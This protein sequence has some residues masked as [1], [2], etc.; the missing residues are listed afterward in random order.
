MDNLE[1]DVPVEFE[2]CFC[3][4]K[5][6]KEYTDAEGVISL[7]TSDFHKPICLEMRMAAASRQV[8]QFG[9]LPPDVA[10][11]HQ[12][13]LQQQQQQLPAYSLASLMPIISQSSSTSSSYGTTTST[14][15]AL[16]LEVTQRYG[17][18]I[19]SNFNH[20]YNNNFNTTTVGAAGL[21]GLGAVGA[22]NG[23]L[24]FGNGNYAGICSIGGG[25]GIGS[26]S[27][28]NNNNNADLASVD[29]SDTYA[30]CQTHPFLSQGDLTA[31]FNDEACALDIDMDNLYINP[32]EKESCRGPN[33]SSSTGFI[34]GLPPTI[35]ASGLTMRAQ[36]KKSASGDTALRNLAAGGL[37]PLDDVYQNFDVQ[38]RGSRVS[39]NENSVPKHRKTRFQQSFTSMRPS[40]SSSSKPRARFEDTKLCEDNVRLDGT[41]SG[42][43]SGAS[44]STSSA[45]AAG[46]GG[47]KKKRSAF[48]PGKSLATATKLINQRLFGIQ[49]AGAK[50]KFESKHSSSIDSIDA[51]PNLEHHRRSKSILKNKS[52]VSRVLS[53]PES[54]RLLADNM[55]GSGVSDNGT[56]MGESGSDYSPNKL[57]HS[58]LA[59]SIS[60]PPLRHRTLMHQRSGP[61]TLQSKPTKFQTPRYPEEQALR[62]VKPVLSRSSL[63]TQPSADG[64]FD[65]SQTRDSSLDSETTFTSPVRQTQ[66][67]A[68][69]QD[70]VEDEAEA[71]GGRG[72]R[73]GK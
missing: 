35:S 14:T 51:S 27:N 59:K 50:A 72:R 32:L 55:S 8:N 24:L 22:A 29:S 57:P 64:R 54:E 12:Q 73:R 47:S 7:P 49:N 1:Q 11:S 2:C 3:T 68:K 71:E 15:I 16:P 21:G 60:P 45:A 28:S 56:V 37:S 33:I 58:V 34:V 39:L 25:I 62:Q 63:S 70:K 52:D 5:D 41:G 30:S 65:P 61:A 44:T 20:N 42:S 6:L 10:P 38:E 9:L 36:V 67:V 66:V 43:G 69:P 4:T 26:S 23:M 53:D 17:A 13:R 31:D 19:A 40:S 46:V 48:M 18:P